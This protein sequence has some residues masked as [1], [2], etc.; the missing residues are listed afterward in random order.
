MA[1]KASPTVA[2]AQRVQDTGEGGW[3][4]GMMFFVGLLFLAAFVALPFVM[5]A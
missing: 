2:H 4:C 1:N 5:G 3:P